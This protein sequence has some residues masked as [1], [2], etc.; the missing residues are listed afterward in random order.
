[1][2]DIL[3]GFIII[4]DLTSKIINLH[5]HVNH[6]IQCSIN[7]LTGNPEDQM[8]FSLLTLYCSSRQNYMEIN[9]QVQ[10]WIHYK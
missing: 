6:I 4:A 2:V 3:S 9:Y 7:Q 10:W 1:M 5:T 8:E